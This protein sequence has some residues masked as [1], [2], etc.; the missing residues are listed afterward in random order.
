MPDFPPKKYLT[1][2]EIL[3]ATKGQWSWR[4]FQKLL[5]C[6]KLKK[7]YLGNHAAA[8]YSKANVLEN[9]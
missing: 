4:Y 1:R 7:I 2:A 8:R 5:E 9:C 6:K 3:R